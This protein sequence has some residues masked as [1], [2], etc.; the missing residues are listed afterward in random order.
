MNK[1]YS[2][3]K[4]SLLSSKPSTAIR[5]LLMVLFVSIIPVISFRQST[6]TFNEPGTYT[7]TVSAGVAS[8]TVQA[9]GAGSG[10]GNGGNG[11]GGGG[12]AKSTFADTPGSTYYYTVGVSGLAN[13]N[14]GNLS[15]ESSTTPSLVASGG[16]ISG[17]GGI[18]TADTGTSTAFKMGA[19]GGTY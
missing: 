18:G 13:N 3:S 6:Q 10:S 19:K 15:F 7:F 9:W 4:I 12:Y 2:I 17:D 14:G 16:I 11:G 5:L 1:N 8:I